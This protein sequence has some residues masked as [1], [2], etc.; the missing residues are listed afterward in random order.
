MDETPL[1]RTFLTCAASGLPG[2]RPEC[3]R[4]PAGG[5]WSEEF[6]TCERCTLLLTHKNRVSLADLVAVSLADLIAVSF[7]ELT[8]VR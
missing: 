1:P 3:D 7:G 5:L 4:T 2:T 8:V 6:P